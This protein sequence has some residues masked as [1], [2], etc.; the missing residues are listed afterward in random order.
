MTTAFTRISAPAN[1]LPH[2]PQVRLRRLNAFEVLT[3]DGKR[4]GIFDQVGEMA[5]MLQLVE[6]APKHQTSG[7]LVVDVP[8]VAFPFILERKEEDPVA[9]IKASPQFLDALKAP[10]EGGG[11]DA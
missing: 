4:L 9:V 7:Q 3:L 8:D 10:A 6:R 2:R 1:G 5:G 11:T